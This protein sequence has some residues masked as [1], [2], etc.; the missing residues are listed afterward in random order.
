MGRTKADLPQHSGQLKTPE[1]LIRVLN[2]LVLLS[3]FELRKILPTRI[4]SACDFPAQL[5]DKLA[6][7]FINRGRTEA[8]YGV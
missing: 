2:V 4:R 5:E 8:E 7:Q 3:A 6:L 1:W